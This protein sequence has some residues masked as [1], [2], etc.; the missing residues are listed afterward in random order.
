MISAPHSKTSLKKSQ[1]P[2]LLSQ[3]SD[4]VAFVGARTARAKL[5]RRLGW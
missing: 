2:A 3:I 1:I 5:A 4:D